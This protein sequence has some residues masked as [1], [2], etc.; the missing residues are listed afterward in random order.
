MARYKLQTYQFG[1]VSGIRQEIS[2]RITSA[3]PGNLFAPEARKGQLVIISEAVNESARSKEAC[4]LVASTI[5]TMYYKDSSFSVTSS[6]RNALKEANSRLYEFNFKAAHHQKTAVGVTCAVLHKNDLYIAQ[7]QPTQA[8]IAHKGQLRALPTY[9]SWQGA[10]TTSSSVLPPNALGTSLFSEPEMFRNVIEPNDEVILCSSRL[11]RVVGRAEA[12]RLFCLED[13]PSA[14]EEL[15]VI[16]HRNQLTEAHIA[17]L[18]LMPLVDVTVGTPLSPEGIAERSKAAASVVGE[19]LSDVTGNAALLV[20]RPGEHSDGTIDA[21]T[22]PQPTSAVSEVPKIPPELDE[23][24]PRDMN[25]L[26]GRPRYR[27][28]DTSEVDTWLPSAYIGE[29]SLTPAL[30]AAASMSSVDLT[31]LEPLPVDFAAIPTRDPL[32]KPSASDSI[33]RPLRAMLAAI[34]TFLA[35]FGRRRRPSAGGLPRFETSGGLSYRRSKQ[36]KIPYTLI[37]FLL[38]VMV[39]SYLYLQNRT[40]QN[41]EARYQE[42]LNN[43]SSQFSQANSATTDE[44]ALTELSELDTLLESVKSDTSFMND[45]NRRAEYQTIRNKADQLRASIDRT[46]FLNEL[47]PVVTMPTNDAI[48]HM[49][50]QP[51]GTSNDIYFVGSENGIVYK[52]NESAGGTPTALLKE[53]DLVETIPAAPIRSILWREGALAV[54]DNP[55]SNSRSNIYFYD[56]AAN[57]WTGSSI[58]ASEL[59]TDTPFP[60]IE[61]FG[62]NLYVWDSKQAEAGNAQI[63]KYAS[64]EYAN[65]PTTW[66]TNVP[67]N[68]NLKT[69]VDIAID[70]QIYMLQP[71]GAIEVLNGGSWQQ[72]QSIAAPQIDPPLRAKHLFAEIEPGIQSFDENKGDFFIIDIINRR[73]VQINRQGKV[74][75]Q[76]RAPS[77]SS[78]QLD[79]LS[80][81]VVTGSGDARILYLADGNTIYK[82]P[83]P[84]APAQRVIPTPSTGTGTPAVTPTP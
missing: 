38:L 37:L 79:K 36:R 4:D 62:G 73:I 34:A 57:S 24:D 82:M 74:V 75:Q 26:R 77:S 50:I 27:P 51:N 80:D 20:R 49:L 25:W 83:L 84:K 72:A 14:I 78:I 35:N 7:V 71:N 16:A 54:V 56:A 32:P 68:L 81:L 13:A 10:N 5:S 44:A 60:D 15:Y 31:D 1:I 11:A 59:W 3:M 47:Q 46:S 28:R 53:G 64:G 63:Q 42:T 17:L 45:A 33:K 6:L 21:P 8:Y 12:E 66:I 69:A 2:D 55:T 39:A 9:P 65:L 22:E 76:L 40:I 61:T 58:Q 29:T 18:E 52:F 19:W 23:I 48:A 70:G 41:A 43:L 67:E 30:Q